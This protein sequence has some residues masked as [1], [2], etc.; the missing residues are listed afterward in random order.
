MA[1]DNQLSS[2]ENLIK[3]GWNP[4]THDRNGSNALHW[5]SGQGNIDIVKYL[6]EKHQMNPGLPYKEKDGR[7]PFHWAARNGKLDVVQYCL[8]NGV[9]IDVK[10]RDWTTPLMLAC[11]G[12]QLEMV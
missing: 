10:T 4:L 12:G 3:N 1:R 6:V 11:Y 2:L 9:P 5:A 8:A 7:S